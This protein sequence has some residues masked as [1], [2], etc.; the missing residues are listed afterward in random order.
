MYEDFGREHITEDAVLSPMLPVHLVMNA[1]AAYVTAAL[2]QYDGRRM[3]VVADYIDEGD[4]GQSAVVLVRRAQLDAPGKVLRVTAPA[5]HFDQNRN[6]GL[7]AALARVPIDCSIGGDVVQGR[8]EIQALLR[9][10]VRGLPA[11]QVNAGARW[12]LN[13]LAG[14]Y[15]RALSPGGALVSEPEDNLYTTLMAGIESFCALTRVRA[16]GDLEEG[17]NV[18][19]AADGRKYRSA[20][21]DRSK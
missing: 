15:C 1:K 9:S 19:T 3:T 21:V 4:P 11:I 8:Q 6:V 2:L 10:T 16:G 20:M 12:T 13:G 17:A 14:G 5:I 18:R 7:R